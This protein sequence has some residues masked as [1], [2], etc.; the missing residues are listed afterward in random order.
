MTDL[1]SLPINEY[2]SLLVARSALS[3]KRFLPWRSVYVKRLARSQRQL[4]GVTSSLVC[5][6]AFIAAISLSLSL[7]LS[8]CLSL[9]LFFF[10]SMEIKKCS[11]VKVAGLSDCVEI[12]FLIFTH[13]ASKSA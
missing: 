12:A 2:L 13:V 10:F 8:T 11:K 7:S 3:Q 6:F 4:G 9:C 5:T 1:I